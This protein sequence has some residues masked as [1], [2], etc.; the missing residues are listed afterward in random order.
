MIRNLSGGKR[1]EGH[2]RQREEQR[3]PKVWTSKAVE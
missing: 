3:A 1:Q 2:S